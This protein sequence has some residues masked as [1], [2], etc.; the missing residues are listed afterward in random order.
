MA[1]VQSLLPGENGAIGGSAAQ[2]CINRMQIGGCMNHDVFAAVCAQQWPG[3]KQEHVFA[4]PR[5]WRFDLAWPEY[6]VACEIEGGV[7]IKGRHTR[8]KGYEADC[9]KYSTA[10][11]YGWRVIRVTPGMIASGK[12]LALL[13]LAFTPAGDVL[14]DSVFLKRQAD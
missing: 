8:G 14:H 11:A 6:R 9:E 4:S 13:G 5:K 12:A 2:N 7:W 3:M 1:L 10:A